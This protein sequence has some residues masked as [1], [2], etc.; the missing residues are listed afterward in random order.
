MS[1]VNLSEHKKNFS[2]RSPS[3]V[4]KVVKATAG[5]ASTLRLAPLQREAAPSVL[6]VE[7]VAAG[8]SDI[9]VSPRVRP[10]CMAA[11]IEI[12]VETLDGSS[13]H[14]RDAAS[15]NFSESSEVI[16][17]REEAT[18]FQTTA[19]AVVVG[20]DEGGGI[21]VNDD[22]RPPIVVISLL[23]SFAGMTIAAF[24]VLG[25]GKCVPYVLRSF[26][27]TMAFAA[28]DAA[29]SMNEISDD[30][31]EPNLRTP[32][33]QRG[34]CWAV[35]GILRGAFEAIGQTTFEQKRARAAWQPAKLIFSSI[36]KFM[37]VQIGLIAGMMLRAHHDRRPNVGKWY[38]V[39]I[40]A[41]LLRDIGDCSP[42]PLVYFIGMA[43]YVITITVGLYFLVIHKDR[44]VEK[45]DVA[46]GY[47]L[48]GGLALSSIQRATLLI[49]QVDFGGQ[50]LINSAVLMLFQKV[51]L[52]VVVPAFKRCYGNDNNRKLWSF[53]VPAAT[54]A[55]EVGPC[56]LFLELRL[57]QPEFWILIFMQ[58]I[59]SVFKNVGWSDDLYTR[60]RQCIGRPISQTMRDA[61]EEK[62]QVIAPCDNIAEIA[63]PVILYLVIVIE[64]VFDVLPGVHRTPYSSSD[65]ILGAWMGDRQRKFRGET[66]ITLLCVFVIRII[67]CLI[68]HKLRELRHKYNSTKDGVCC[69]LKRDEGSDGSADNHRGSQRNI[70]RRSSISVLFHRVVRS[71]DMPVHMQYFA[72]ATFAL[73]PVLLVLNAAIFGKQFNDD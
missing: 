58:E 13:I 35:I 32:H 18:T 61:M 50:L 28:V 23:V 56:L 70:P 4:G 5:A 65:G 41:S 33:K 2:V 1:I 8:A 16:C 10:L 60:L 20:T 34:M 26:L 62:R 46:N 69:T 30:M 31:G 71:K 19:T 37:F 72:G 48:L 14:D 11:V 66:R 42:Y 22:R 9:A 40:F 6:K 47:K 49:A 7:G 15:S 12:D 44:D 45:S 29:T 25:G 64:D 55:S 24:G 59:G 38:F 21:V 27:E 53:A 3:V 39:V 52:K 51:V 17:T 57:S 43:I 68:E 63:C 67:F 73:Q 54:L 36:P